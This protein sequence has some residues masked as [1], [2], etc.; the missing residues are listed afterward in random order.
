MI[1]TTITFGMAIVW[2]R[3]NGRDDDDTKSFAESRLSSVNKLFMILL[4]LSCV[5]N[6]IVIIV[7]TDC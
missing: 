2:L 6:T 3:I 1:N 4:L 7:F 5:P